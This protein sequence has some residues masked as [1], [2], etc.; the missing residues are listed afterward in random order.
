VVEGALADPE[1]SFDH[2]RYDD[3]L[4]AVEQAVDGGHV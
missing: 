1:H 3:G 4:D 2:Y